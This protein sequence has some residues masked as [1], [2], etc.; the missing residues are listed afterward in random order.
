MDAQSVIQ[1]A[2]NNTLIIVGT[3][4]KFDNSW[5]I[6]CILTCG[7]IYR[8]DL[9]INSCLI[10]DAHSLTHSFSLLYVVAAIY[11]SYLYQSNKLRSHFQLTKFQT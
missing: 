7:E 6:D 11:T 1:L 2:D 3:N 5:V 9:K 10:V 4:P 8:Y